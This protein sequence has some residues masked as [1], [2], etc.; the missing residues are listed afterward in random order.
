VIYLFADLI[1]YFKGYVEFYAEGI[2]T[3]KF[4]TFCSKNGVEFFEPQKA[5]Y[6]LF[7]K[8]DL[9]NYK[10][11]R[12]PARKNGL[13]LKIIK[14]HGFYCFAKQNKRKIGFV[15]GSVFIILFSV[16]MNYFIWEINI[17]GNFKT[18]KTQIMK[19]AEEMGLFTGTLSKKHSV[20]DM[21]WYILRE[22]PGLASVEINIQGSVA[23]ILIH[24]RTE[25]PE[26][27]SDDD[28]PVN[29]IASKYGII[30]EVNVFD[31]QPSVK[32]GDAVLKGD[33][34]VSAVY[35]D[36]HNKLT[37]KHA[38]AEVIAETDYIITV[39]FPLEEKIF[40]KDGL[41]KKVYE[42]IF[43]GKK[44]CFGNHE[45][46]IDLPSEK[47]IEKIKF[48]GLELPVTRIVTRYFSVKENTIIYNFE[49]GRSKAFELLEAKEKELMAEM[50]ILSR[51]T[52]EKI[53]NGKYI[54][55]ADYIVLMDISEE[56][57]IESDIPWENSD[58]MS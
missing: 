40:K 52:E 35:E 49:Q 1:R 55:N 38:R 21:E 9:K 15:L 11:L 26:M 8:T 17:I 39:E 58:D 41:K 37:L 57:P 10:K 51:K 3:E 42:T 50:E 28:V 53:K 46:F 7:L 36:R 2:E 27:V 4:Y 13:K 29:L 34:L 25:V 31:G 56:Q 19:S 32:P 33:L 14:K 20:Q 12:I 23:N 47:N 54:I 48:F 6:R 43:L 24:E 18:D 22:N 5:G 45:E 44:I 16:F 30:K